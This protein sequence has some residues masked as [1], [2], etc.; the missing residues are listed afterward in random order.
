MHHNYIEIF[1]ILVFIIAVAKLAG[2]LS[3]R[4]GQP[5]VL[6]EIAA[7]LI[8]GPTLLAIAY[9]PI[10]PE[11]YHTHRE[12]VAM[13]EA[14]GSLSEDKD[15]L[16][17]KI[18]ELGSQAGE[19]VEG[20][21]IIAGLPEEQREIIGDEVSQQIHLVDTRS[22]ECCAPCLGRSVP[23]CEFKLLT[24]VLNGVD[25]KVDNISQFA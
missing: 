9:W 13:Q 25:A 22:D 3:Q 7:G 14:I 5:A 11:S 8:L 19:A 16:Q 15:T 6:G 23:W 4:L 20:L 2:V 18:H 17:E 12:Q 24:F 1:L 21:D 10:F